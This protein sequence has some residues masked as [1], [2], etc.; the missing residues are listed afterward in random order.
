MRPA[1][2]VPALKEAVVRAIVDRL[3]GWTQV[4]AAELLRTDQPRVS[5]LRNGRLHRFSLEKLIRFAARLRADVTV[6][7]RWDPHKR[8]LASRQ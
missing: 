3:D 7:V 6:D 5:D 2:P 4:N 8:Y 1:D